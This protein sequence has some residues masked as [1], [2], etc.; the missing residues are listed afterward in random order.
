M[1]QLADNRIISLKNIVWEQDEKK[2]LNQV[3]WDVQKGEHWALLGLNGS[4]KT[5]LLKMITGYQWPSSGE[6]SV[7]GERFGNTN[8]PELRKKIGW[9]SS[10]LDEQFQTRLSDTAI[11]VVLSGKFASIGVYEK[12]TKEDFEKAHDIL[13]Q[14]KIEHL[15][16]RPISHLSQGERRRVMISRALISSP[17]LLILDEPCNGLDIYAKEEL[18]STIENMS[19]TPDGPTILYVTHYIEEIVPSI[20]HALLINS[21]EVI[22]SGPKHATLTAESIERTFQVPV[23]LEWENE[24]PWIR[25][26]SF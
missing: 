8:I 24:R 7:L 5:S 22:A 13:T 9:V 10:S 20:S 14:F 19:T 23:S 2:I 12:V 16:D 4:G 6:V 17:R 25:V 21:G 26:K 11:E 18:L 3:S 1:S 15:F